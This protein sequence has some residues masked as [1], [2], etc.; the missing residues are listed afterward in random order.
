MAAC[1][2]GKR[3]RGGVVLFGGRLHQHYEEFFSQCAPTV[4]LWLMRS[5]R[6]VVPRVN[7][8]GIICPVCNMNSTIARLHYVMHHSTAD[9]LLSPMNSMWSTHLECHEDHLLHP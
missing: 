2:E 1:V 5:S 4:Q 6:E 7:V 8:A 9:Y 3:L